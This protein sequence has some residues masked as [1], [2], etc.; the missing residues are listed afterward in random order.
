MPRRPCLDCGRLTANASRCDAHAAVWNARVERRRGSS[1]ARGY[2]AAWRRVARVVLDRHKAIYG[3]R[4][5]GFGIPPHAASDLTVDHIIP[6]S[7]GGSD[8]PDNLQVLCRGCNS[9]KH[10]RRG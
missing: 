2:G 7:A 9:R 4:C 10:N 3:F 5:P 1:T 8:Q 6:R